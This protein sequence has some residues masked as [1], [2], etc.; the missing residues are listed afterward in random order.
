MALGAGL[1]SREAS[2]RQGSDKSSTGSPERN[3]DEE[4]ITH[5][6]ILVPGTGP[7][8]EDEKPKGMFMKKAQRFRS[9]LRET[10]KREF[11][12]TNACVE[13]EPIEFHADMHALESANPR[14]DSVTLPSI[15][16]IRTMDNEVIGDILYYFTSFHGHRMLEIVICKLNDA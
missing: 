2:S 6:A 13:M 3:D 7:H 16:W 5:Y 1:F 10:C 9:M 11:A 14:M 4:E 8:R 12:S 15:P